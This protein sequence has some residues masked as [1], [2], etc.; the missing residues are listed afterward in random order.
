MHEVENWPADVTVSEPSATV[1]V[2]GRGR[3]LKSLSLDK[4]LGDSLSGGSGLVATTGDL[5]I[6]DLG[7]T[8]SSGRRAPRSPLG[9]RRSQY[10]TVE[11][12]YGDATAR[13]FTGVTDGV[14]AGSDGVTRLDVVDRYA[15]LE[16]EV[17][18]DPLMNVMPAYEDGGPYRRVG[19]S[20]TYV[21]SMLL[22]ECEFYATPPQRSGASISVPMNGSM[23]AEWGTI[24][25]CD[26]LSGSSGV[27]IL[28]RAPWGAASKNVQAY[29]APAFPDNQSNDFFIQFLVGNA[30]TSLTSSI[31]AEWGSEMVTVE[32]NTSRR[33]SVYHVT[34]S[35]STLVVRLTPEVVEGGTQV[36]LK[37][38]GSTWT[39]TT[40]AGQSVLGVREF[41]RGNKY[42]QVRIQVPRDGTQ[43][44]GVQVGA[45]N[46]EYTQFTPNASLGPSAHLTG[47][48]AMPA[49]VRERVSSLLKDQA[50]AELAALW[51]DDYGRLVWRNRHDLITGSPVKTI[52][53]EKDLLDVSWRLPSRTTTR[54][55]KAV[56]KNPLMSVSPRATITVYQG[57][58]QSIDSGELH[59]EVYSPGSDEDWVMPNL[60]GRWVSD[61]QPQLPGF[62]RQRRTWVGMVL[63]SEGSNG[64]MIENQLHRDDYIIDK[65][66][67][68]TFVWNATAPTV[69]DHISVEMRAPDSPLV[70]AHLR[71]TGLPV[72]RAY[73]LIQWVDISS[74]RP[75]EENGLQEHVHDCKWFIQT[76]SALDQIAAAV[77]ERVV[78]DSPVMESVP[79]IPDA[80][81]EVG[82]IVTLNDS[83]IMGLNLRC[84]IEGI[85]FNASEGEQ[86]MSLD[87]RILQ[88][89]GEKATYADLEAK[90]STG[91]YEALEFAWSGAPYSSFENNPLQGG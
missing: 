45:F 55:V 77:A 71:G 86:D 41:T 37:I 83:H 73:G 89:N 22:R 84:L 11:A 82:D 32:V 74:T 21:T 17:T 75:G 36:T 68:R 60:M 34:S 49:I 20:P 66:D 87:L 8:V 15:A 59:T 43:I 31:R 65:I 88:V 85:K 24:M 18:K 63:K 57:S 69:A 9:Y 58:G 29:V 3:S 6:E 39:L 48:A 40:S 7:A 2:D 26:R 12:G 80:R 30:G 44:A 56:A 35:G 16:I 46:A 47:M 25:T 91:Q 19:M 28:E 4:S 38:S 1:Q 14:Q 51:I 27:P 79:I 13:V 53:S 62:N 52:T 72:I 67:P 70:W 61:Q 81:L 78:G 50:E 54:R 23:W 90:W 64:E 33:V 5:E 10:T 42:D 76:Q